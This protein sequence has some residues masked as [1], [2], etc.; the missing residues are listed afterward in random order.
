MFWGE[1]VTMSKRTVVPTSKYNPVTGLSPI[2]N[3]IKKIFVKRIR[4]F[5]ISRSTKLRNRQ[6]SLKIYESLNDLDRG[7]GAAAPCF[8]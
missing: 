4:R 6:R 7:K 3:G 8:T 5:R 1:S 2:V